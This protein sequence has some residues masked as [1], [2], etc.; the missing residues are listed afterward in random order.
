MF[1]FHVNVIGVVHTI[2][3]FLPLLKAGQT[4]KVIAISSG[5]GDLDVTL[6]GEFDNGVAYSISKAALNM[7]I[8]KYAVAYKS[9]GFLFL[10]VAPGVVNTAVEPPTDEQLKAFMP[11]MKKI[12]TRYPH[13][14]GPITPEESVKAVLHVIDEA[15]LKDTGAFISQHGNKEWV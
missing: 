1:Q 12:Q 5:F 13:F 3:V 15:T 4:K 8:G 9:D 2:N 11:V 6:E 14:Q 7:A 10:S